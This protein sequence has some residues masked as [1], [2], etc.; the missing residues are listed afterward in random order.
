QMKRSAMKFMGDDTP[1][2]KI[3]TNQPVMVEGMKGNKLIVGGEEYTFEEYSE[4]FT[5]VPYTKY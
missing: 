3:G 2:Y 1:V 5:N 4:K